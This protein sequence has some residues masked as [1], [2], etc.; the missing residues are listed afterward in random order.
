MQVQCSS[1]LALPTPTAP[2]TALYRHTV[3]VP[4]GSVADV[5]VPLLGRSTAE[6]AITESGRPVWQNGAFVAGVEGVSTGSI[7]VDRLGAANAVRFT[8]A[9]GNYVL[10]LS[11]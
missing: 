6:I 5:D 2:Q 9:Q 3:T 11:A 7:S 1:T 10:E 4:P 8:I